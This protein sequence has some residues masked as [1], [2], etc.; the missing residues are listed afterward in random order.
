MLRVYTK[1]QLG[2]MCES[3]DSYLSLNICLIRDLK[4]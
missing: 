1:K 2:L 3:W 4:N